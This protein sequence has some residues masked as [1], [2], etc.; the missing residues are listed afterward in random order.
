MA[1]K[2][3]PESQSKQAS[4]QEGRG[5]EFLTSI[6]R[7]RERE[8]EL[9]QQARKKART[10]TASTAPPLGSDQHFLLPLQIILSCTLF[11]SV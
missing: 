7:E 5:L 3:Q 6:E 8:T 4:I 2:Q 10:A 11:L 9:G 1:N